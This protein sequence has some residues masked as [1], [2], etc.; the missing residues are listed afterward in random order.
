MSQPMNKYI[1]EVY[2]GES[3][4]ELA[5]WESDMPFGNIAVGNTLDPSSWYF[6]HDDCLFRIAALDHNIHHVDDDF[7][8]DI[9]HEIRLYCDREAL[10]S[11][12][13]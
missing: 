11:S 7:A 1:L 3:G 13:S 5:R 6:P 4:P 10:K 9:V 8:I 2:E 12:R